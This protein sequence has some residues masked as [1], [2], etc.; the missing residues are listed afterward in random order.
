M[1]SRR[2]IISILQYLSGGSLGRFY[3]CVN[4]AFYFLDKQSFTIRVDVFRCRCV[5]QCNLFTVSRPP[6]LHTHT[7]A[8]INNTK[9]TLSFLP[10]LARW[11]AGHNDSLFFCRPL[12]HAFCG[13]CVA[14]RRRR[15]FRWPGFGSG[16]T[17]SGIFVRTNGPNNASCTTLHAK[18][19]R[20]LF[21]PFSQPAFLLQN[22]I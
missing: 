9:R 19:A 8:H 6:P 21:S 5:L 12:S 18:A 3:T 10:L 15:K 20:L 11:A 14:G 2:G 22:N 17:V 7:S 13:D 1:G 16:Q 4:C